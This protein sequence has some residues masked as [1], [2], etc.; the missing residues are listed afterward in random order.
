[1]ATISLSEALLEIENINT[2][3]GLIDLLERIDITSQNTNDG[4]KTVLYSGIGSLPDDLANSRMVRAIDKTDAANLIND[5]KFTNALERIFGSATSDEAIDFL[6]SPH[7]GTGG[8]WDIVSRRFVDDTAGEIVTLIGENANPDRIFFQT[9]WEAVKNNSNITTVNGVARDTFINEMATLN[10]F[11][12][13]KQFQVDTI[14]RMGIADDLGVS[15]SSLTNDQI[16]EFLAKTDGSNSTVLRTIESKVDALL[17]KNTKIVLS[18]FFNKLPAIGTGIGFLLASSAA[19]AASTSEEADQIMVDWAADESGSFVGEEIGAIVG[20]VAIGIAAAVGVTF[21]AIPTAIIIGGAA[22]V[23]GFIGSDLAKDLTDKWFQDSTSEDFKLA[24]FDNIA[25]FQYVDTGGNFGIVTYDSATDTWTFPTGYTYEYLQT[26]GADGFAAMLTILLESGRTSETLPNV[27]LGGQDY[28]RVRYYIDPSEANFVSAVK[29]G[30]ETLLEQLIY[31]RPFG[32]ENIRNNPADYSF[33]VEDYSDTYLEQ[34]AASYVNSVYDSEWYHWGGVFGYD[35]HYIDVDGNVDVGNGLQDL[36]F[37]GGN[38]V[39]DIIDGSLLGGDDHLFGMGGNDVLYGGIGDDYLEGGHG[40]DEMYGGLGNDTFYIQGTDESYDNFNGGTGQDTILGSA[41]D[42]TIRLHELTTDSSIEII[43][44]DGGDNNVIAGTNETDII[45]L[46]ATTISNI[47]AIETGENDDTI[48]V[49]QEDLDSGLKK[50]DGGSGDGDTLKGTDKREVFDFNKIEITGIEKINTGGGSDQIKIK[51]NTTLT[52]FKEINGGGGATLIGTSGDDVWDFSSITL[53]GVEVLNTGGGVD[54]VYIDQLSSGAEGSS[55]ITSING[56]GGELVVKTKADQTCIDLSGLG[57]QDIKKVKIYGS[58]SVNEIIGSRLDDVIYGGTVLKGGAGDDEYHVDSGDTLSDSDGSGRVVFSELVLT[59]GEAA[60]GNKDRE[61]K[62]Y[63][64]NSGETYKLDGSTLT[65]SYNGESIT[66]ENFRKGNLGIDLEDKDDP[67]DEPE[68]DGNANQHFS[69]PLVL[70]LNGNG[71]TSQ[72]IL[73]STVHFD[74]DGDGFKEKVGWVEAGDGLLVL[75]RDQNGTIDNGNELFGNYTKDKNSVYYDNGFDALTA[76]DGNADGVIDAKDDVYHSL[77]IWQDQNQDGISQADEL[78]TL[79]DLQIESIDLGAVEVSVEEAQNNISHESSFIQAGTD[80]EGNPVS[81]EKIVRD[82]WFLRDTQ[83]TIYDF[84]KTIPDEVEI[85]PEMTGSGR[86]MDLSHAMTGDVALREQVEAFLDSSDSP[87]SDLYSQAS[88]IL[89]RWTHTDDIDANETRG[90]Q[91]ILNHNYNDPQIKSTFRVYATARD[92]AIL[93]CFAGKTF[94]TLV[95]GEWTTDIVGTEASQSITEK[96]AFLRDTLVIT[97]LAQDLFGKDIYDAVTGRFDTEQLFSR[98]QE[99]LTAGTDLQRRDTS[100]NLLSSLLSR[101]RLSVFEYL[102]ASVLS[103]P[104]IQNLLL[105]NDIDLSISAE[106]DVVGRIKDLTYSSPGDDQ[107]S[108]SGTL[109]G[110]DGNDTLTGLDGHDVLYGGAGDDVLDG[111]IG[112]DILYGGDGND[113]LKTGGGY[114]H[115]I[116]IGGRGDDLMTGSKRSSTYV[117]TYGDGNDTI[118]DQGQVGNTPDVLQFVGVRSDDVHLERQN[119]DIVIFIRDLSVENGGDSGSIRIKNGFGKG[120]IE[121]FEFEDQVLDINQLLFGAGYYDSDY[122]YTLSNGSITIN[123]VNGTDRLIFGDGITS[124]Q[125]M[126]KTSLDNDDLVIGIKEE[127]VSF[128]DLT[129]KITI[130]QG[131]ANGNMIEEFIFADGSSIGL[132][133]LLQ[134]QGTDTGEDIRLLDDDGAVNALGGDDNV[135]AGSGN[136]QITGGLG[137][138][139]LSGGTGDDI[140]IFHKGDGR[141]IVDD[142]GGN[143]ILRFGEGISSDDLV[144]VRENDDVLVGILEDGKEFDE[145]NDIITFKD[146][147]QAGKRIETI[148][149]AS[150]DSMDASGILTELVGSSGIVYGLET[151]DTIVGTDEDNIIFG[152]GG[153]DQIV[154]GGGNDQLYGQSGNDTLAGGRDDDYLAGGAG[155]DRYVYSRGDGH[156][157]IVDEYLYVDGVVSTQGNGGNDTLLFGSSISANDLIFVR[158]NDDL[159]IGLKEEGK[160]FEQLADTICL[161]NWYHANT[162]IEQ[163]EFADGTVLGAGELIQFLGTQGDDQIDGLDVDSVFSS[164]LGDDSLVGFAGND[165]YHFAPGHGSETILDA[166]GSDQLI[167]AEG[168]SPQDL[169]IVWQQ[170]TSDIVITCKGNP[171]DQITLHGWYDP[172]SRIETIRFADGT[173]WGITDVINAMG[174]DGEDVYNGLN[175]IDNFIQARGGDDLVSTYGGNDTLYGGNGADGL[176]AQGGNDTLVGGAGDDHLW[177][178]A[179]DDIYIYNR[180]DGSDLIYDGDPTGADAG[181]DILRLGAGIS[182]EDLIFR[183][184]PDSNDLFIGIADPANPDTAFDALTNK[185]TISNWYVAKNRIETIELTETGES[186]SVSE[187]MAAMGTDGDDTI[188]ALSEGSVLDGQLG[189][190]TLYGNVGDDNLAGNAGDDYLAGNAGDDVLA[191]GGGSDQLLGEGGNDT[192]LFNRGDG[193]DTIFDSVISSSYTYGW[194]TNEETGSRRWDRILTYAPSEGGE[195][196]VQFGDG[197]TPEDLQVRTAGNDITIAIKEDGKVFD[198]LSDKLTITDFY[199]AENKIE[200]F[201]FSDGQTLTSQEMLNL[202]FTEGDDDVVFETDADQIVFAKGG[203]DTVVGGGGDDQ[204]TGGGGNDVLNGSKGDDTYFFGQGDGQDTIEDKGPLDWW[205]LASGNDTIHLQGGLTLDEVV[206]AWGGALSE[207]NANDLIIAIREDGV[208]LPELADRIVVKDWFNRQTKVETLSF[209]DGTRLDAQ[210]IMNA[211]FTEGADSIDIAGADMG[212]VLNSLGGDDTITATDSID[213]IDAGEGNDI[214]FALGGD[215]TIAAGSG[216]DIVYGND[217]KDVISGDTGND[218]LYGGAGG[219][220]YLFSRGDGADLIDDSVTYEQFEYSSDRFGHVHWLTLSQPANAGSDT[221]QFGEGITADELLFFWDQASQG[222][223]DLIIALKDPDSPD[224]SIEEL[225]DKITVKNWFYRDP[226]TTDNIFDLEDEDLDCTVSHR[227]YLNQIEQL[228]FSDGTVLTGQDLLNAMASDRDD[229]LEGMVG[230]ESTLVGLAGNDVLTGQDKSDTLY[231]GE[232]DD[233]LDGG[234]GKNILDGG[235]GNDTYVLTAENTGPWDGRISDDTLSDADGMDSVLFEND[236]AR[237]DIV[238]ILDGDDLV[239]YYGLELQHRLRIVGNCVERFELSDG[240]Y[241]SRDEVMASLAAIAELAGGS[242]PDA[243][244]LHQDLDLKALQ[245]NAWHDLFVEHQGYDDWNEFSGN[246]D[247]EIV[248]GGDGE[249]RLLGRSGN[250]VLSGSSGDDFLNAGNGNDT[251]R[252]ELQGNNDTILDSQNPLD[253]SGYGAYG[254][255]E[256]YLMAVAVDVGGEIPDADYGCEWTIEANSAPQNDTLILGDGINLDNVEAYWATD[257]TDWMASYV[258]D[259]LLRINTG[260]LEWKDRERNIDTIVAYYAGRTLKERAYNETLKKWVYVERVLTEPDLADFSDK[261]IE[262]LAYEVERGSDYVRYTSY[263]SNVISYLDE[264]SDAAAYNRAYRSEEDTITISHYYDK[265]YTIENIVIEGT[266]Y[267]LTNNDLM[268]L[269]SSNQAEMIR[270]V[271]WADNTINAL[272]GSDLVVGGVLNDTLSGGAGSDLLHGRAGDDQYLFDR[273]SG[274]DVVFEGADVI[275]TVT[276]EGRFWSGRAEWYDGSTL[277]YA[278]EFTSGDNDPSTVETL[279]GVIP[280]AGGYDQVVFGADLSIQEIGF[281]YYYNGG[282]Y[283]GY[284][285]KTSIDNP[286]VDDVTLWQGDAGHYQFVYGDGEGSAIVGQQVYTNDIVLPDQFIDGRSVEEFVMADGSF[287]SCEGILAGL[288]DSLS[289]IKQYDDYLQQVQENG[290]DAKGYV[291]QVFLS[292]WVRQDREIVGSSGNDTLS[293][294][295]GDD[296]ISALDGDDFLAGG[297]GAD[298]LQGGAGNDTYAYNR[299]DGSD[300]IQDVAGVDRLV[301]GEGLA[302]SDFVAELDNVTGRLTLG[303]VDEIS[304]LEAAEAGLTYAPVV[305]DLGQKIAIDDFVSLAGRIETFE[306]AAGTV[307]TDMDLYNHFFTSEQSDELFGLEGDNR[308]YAR[309]GDDIVSL[310]NGNQWVDVGDGDDWVTTGSGADVIYSGTGR[311]TINA[312]AGNDVVFSEGEGNQLAGGAG[313]DAMNGGSGAD[314]YWFAM[315]DGNDEIYDLGGVDTLVIDGFS[316]EITADTLWVERLGD[317]V[318]VQLADGSQVVI[319]DWAVEANRIENIRFADHEVALETLLVL[320]ARNYQVALEED[321]QS[322][323]TIELANAG[324]GVEFLLEQNSVSGTFS[325]SAEGLWAYTPGADANGVDQVVVKV[326]NAQGE[327]AYSTIDFAIAPV[328]DAPILLSSTSYMLQDIRTLSGQLQAADVDGDSVTFHLQGTSDNGTLTMTT[329][330][331]WSYQPNAGFMGTD[332]YNLLIDDGQGGLIETTLDFEVLVSSPQVAPVVLSLDEDTSLAGLLEVVN[333]V[334]GNLTYRINQTGGH[335]EFS[336]DEQGHYLYTPTADFF[337]SDQISVTVTND[338]GLSTTATIDLDILSVNDLPQITSQ[339]TF[340]LKDIRLLSGRFDAEDVDGDLLTWQV[341]QTPQNGTFVLDATGKW[342]YEPNDLFIGSDQVVI[343]VDDGQGGIVSS[344]IIFD[345]QVSAPQIDSLRCVLEEDSCVDGSLVVVNPI[346]GPLTY[347]VIQGSENGALT[348]DDDGHWLYRPDADYHGSDFA[349]VAVTNVYGLTS[350]LQVELTITPVNDLP[351]VVA[352]D[353]YQ[354]LGAVNV[355][356][357]VEATD[358][359]GDSL[360]FT[361]LSPAGHGD[362]VIDASGNWSYVPATGFVGIDSVTVAVDDGQGGTAETTLQFVSNIY[363]SGDI[364]LDDYQGDSLML[365][366]VSKDDLTL[367]RSGD[368]LLVA[369]QQRGSITFADYFLSPE[370]G[371]AVL[372]TVEGP[373]HLAKERIVELEENWCDWLFGG[374]EEGIYSLKNLLYGT[375][376]REILYGADRNDVLF[377][378]ED[379]DKLYGGAGEDTLVGGGGNDQLFGGFDNDTL[380]GDG[381]CDTLR[382]EAGHDALIG[383]DQNDVLYGGEG[384]DWLWGDQGDDLLYGDEGTDQL[385]GSQGNDVLRGGAGDDRYLFESGDGCDQVYDEVYSGFL[386]LCHED[387]GFDVVSFGTSVAKEDVAVFMSCGDLYL[388]YGASDVVKINNQNDGKDSIERFE[389]ADGSFLTDSEM[390]QLVQDLSAYA[391]DHGICM[392]SVTDV[393]NNDDL[394]TLVSGAW[395]Q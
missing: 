154:G 9:E 208:E 276:I 84:D 80:A 300:T 188:K 219:D 393:R 87:L 372:E 202:M 217:G 157:V 32:F 328:N 200:H 371:V 215:D 118:D 126:V 169:A 263:F 158:S 133:Q 55:G 164:T 103:N 92:V 355:S 81:E 64:G 323:G 344:V 221:L 17:N 249:D 373:L 351:V 349:T 88:A 247:N 368:D 378:L 327:E 282:I 31:A 274:R 73:E 56:E 181:A 297:F 156:D 166:G 230:Q 302:L 366:G 159:L 135:S 225:T 336:I 146:W 42:D 298:L 362:F 144:F 343:S 376:N 155:D 183:I 18:K 316:G 97:L 82:V 287:I 256:M 67:E 186:L 54:T 390:N 98:L 213:A 110:G 307:L 385:T 162:R 57:L 254:D 125:L 104:D 367:T 241:I 310:G 89:A 204:I 137:D 322:T 124:D 348:V 130:N 360:T 68:D 100:V 381:G 292:Y 312:G 275:E 108:G 179:G 35:A 266:N 365:D 290:G 333:P 357:R 359:D 109:Y 211:V 25:K 394:M 91:Y 209:D 191:G 119:N 294:G 358:V 293:S 105:A 198:A 153:N 22:L 272:A 235:T 311:D 132:N 45:D 176:D 86:A 384:N 90:V 4:A 143:E 30:D 63:N 223:N 36:V 216:N 281:S 356:G 379:N 121:R 7:G 237:E 283:V 244:S 189:N 167:L 178:G 160:T 129:R 85:L 182:K 107:I 173:I 248:Y 231:G 280:D 147:Y 386:G 246:S 43:D 329:D 331:L 193:S 152:Q 16:T 1:M 305:A 212:H 299:W 330:G 59:G 227:L 392:H 268:D 74:L 116:L 96:Y 313:N 120:Q 206:V 11:E 226:V 10:D 131:L 19:S 207:E 353:P 20:G 38:K 29:S 205:E 259:L 203:N 40:R 195:D 277:C 319:K 265:D 342:Q 318:R 21:G 250:D 47:S 278:D 106:G 58:G 264:E 296:V 383:G 6:Y 347:T 375:N 165:T 69:S 252:F 50:I 267:T 338:Y 44:G 315:G 177:G 224:A 28:G 151:D 291:D 270:G 335:G 24:L 148:E 288:A 380:Y 34:K 123:D 218:T 326:V 382:G 284:G 77:S 271:D 255:D 141:D 78:K 199:T 192:Y 236:I 354:I 66:I 150:G 339:D 238:F 320:Q 170:G 163:L 48:V 70:D 210:G 257:N 364:I 72:S 145:L 185:I 2:K 128:A 387:G 361:A 93:E 243:M 340:L 138:D 346:G 245:Y 187:I 262:Q 136:H 190:D 352:T 260:D 46:S 41:D 258:D 122:T 75:D 62:I 14:Q 115:D 172:S 233:L 369:V 113:T 149:F 279:S 5:K 8:A 117:Y 12:K 180:G 308:I 184:D 194:V 13:F 65:V 114:G 273:T 251:Y 269:M 49:D 52:Q 139:Y 15:A 321:G 239:I 363:S 317:D 37:F 303:I 220:T 374:Y 234:Y 111:G 196:T 285:D 240:S 325:V 140:Y 301:F 370:N 350:L 134:L 261:A 142:E 174:T 61:I 345:V 377:G 94:L 168:I 314:E 341:A 60:E 309:G 33:D 95:D 161:T 102:D 332:Q 229:R 395:H 253:L 76:Y 127:G 201:V 214:V 334:G 197:I 99:E 242:V 232:G 23:G 171:G 112:S 324:D 391:T 101:D 388:S 389:L 295:D 3:E 53:N 306:F 286:D 79:A 289:F 228:V 26:D 51:D 222:A 39:D 83:D 337:G 175:G 27:T 71:I 304:Q